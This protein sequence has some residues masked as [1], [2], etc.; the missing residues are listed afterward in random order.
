MSTQPRDV[1][2]TGMGALNGGSARARQSG[3]PGGAGLPDSPPPGP[4]R[5]GP[6]TAAS[7]WWSWWPGPR[8]WIVAAGLY[9]A[10]AFAIALVLPDPTAL[11]VLRIG[12]VVGELLLLY[13]AIR[14][15]ARTHG[16]AR[17]WRWLLAFS[18]ANTMVA[19][20]VVIAA[21]P[22]GG[23]SQSQFRMTFGQLGYLAPVGTLLVGLLIYPVRRGG[24]YGR[25]PDFL[26]R[27]WWITTLLDS[28]I[29]VGSVG[30][31]SWVLF[32]RRVVGTATGADNVE[33]LVVTM[34]L[35]AGSLLLVCVAL[36]LWIFRRPSPAAGFAL[37]SGGL[38]AISVSLLSFTTKV[39]FGQHLVKDDAE[40][41]WIIAGW[42]FLLA[43]RYPD[44]TDPDEDALDAVNGIEAAAGGKPATIATT[45][46]IGSTEAILSASTGLS[47][48]TILSTYGGTGVRERSGTQRWAHT[49][50]PLLPLAVAVLVILVDVVG[51]TRLE[52]VDIVALLALPLLVLARQTVLLGDNVH[53]LHQLERSER[54]LHRQ[55]FHDPLTGLANRALFGQ[56]LTRALDT[57]A[58]GGHDLAVL[59]VDLDDF[60][61]VN[62]TL[63]HAAG[64]QLLQITAGR[65]AHAVRAGD[66]VARLGGDE[67][68]ILLVSGG[69]AP[70]TVGSRVLAAVRTPAMLAGNRHSVRASVG[71]VVARAAEE[72]SGERLL[73]RADAAMYVAKRAGK[74]SLTIYQPGLEDSREIL[75]GSGRTLRSALIRALRFGSDTELRMSYQP[76]VALPGGEPAGVQ[77]ELR[78]VHPDYGEVS[79]AALV[80]TS[81][82][83][84][85]FPTIAL[86]TLAR[87]CADLPRL[88]AGP[89]PPP[90]H[91]PLQTTV[92]MTPGFLPAIRAARADG[93]LR[94]GELVIDLLGAERGLDVDAW[95]EWMTPL[96]AQDVRLC[97]A[98]L[99]AADSNL[100][101]LTLL[102]IDMVTLTPLITGLWTTRQDDPAFQ[103]R[104]DVLHDGIR[105]M[106]C[107]LGIRI[108]AT[109]L[110]AGD[111][112]GAAVAAGI[113]FAAGRLPALYPPA[114]DAPAPADTLA[115]A[116]VT[117][118]G[119]RDG[120]RTRWSPGPR[121]PPPAT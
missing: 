6:S 16:R 101:L 99:G 82:R 28:M 77:A 106:L 95:R 81:E 85:L 113:D 119:R 109:D 4:T 87:I 5:P 86:A 26:G 61:Q 50:L 21:G 55:A 105:S 78:W 91:L 42:C 108:I 110:P 120:A 118:H 56:R 25:E 14:T 117:R 71:L 92:P 76:I 102:P 10:A 104:L 35:C 11:Y 13:V 20:T 96:S 27:R 115:P 46:A 70:A 51:G 103:F 36:V 47:S 74:G 65:L 72:L 49:A 54:R 66:T 84:E 63:G 57:Q 40:L 9:L 43:C 8:R 33:H 2:M 29:A 94:A 59:Y 37:L 31:L 15:G 73:H 22:V 41:C 67:F 64:D 7:T 34:L 69:E 23:P 112:V 98:D 32:L 53:L 52:A 12:I 68:A 17:W 1:A 88:R 97:L 100:A 24:G 93:R 58:R 111:S 83:A 44:H 48:S 89:T 90:V 114:H 19:G 75:G 38:I 62:D 107:R 80:P 30:I 18:I 121:P 39:A 79:A 60:K 3:P 45:G 116:A